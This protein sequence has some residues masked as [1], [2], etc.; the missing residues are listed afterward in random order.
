MNPALEFISLGHSGLVSVSIYAG[1][2]LLLLLALG[3][4]V[5]LHR[6]RTQ[7]SLGDG[8]DEKIACAVRAH[9][10][11]AEWFP[12]FLIGLTL[13]AITGTPEY[14]IHAVGTAFT[15]GRLLHAWGLTG[16]AGLSFGR[17][18]GSLLTLVC[19]FL[20]GAGLIVHA[21]L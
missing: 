15:I 8:G 21:F 19:Y 3:L 17:F 2:N 1:I 9:A 6:R 4:N 20:L 5:S 10:N 11:H 7:T 16:N 12:G 18:T 13:A 14:A